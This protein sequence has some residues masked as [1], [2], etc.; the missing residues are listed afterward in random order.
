M[1]STSVQSGGAD[2]PEEIPDS[3]SDNGIDKISLSKDG[4]K[5]GRVIG[6]FGFSSIECDTESLEVTLEC[7]LGLINRC[8]LTPRT[9]HAHDCTLW[10]SSCPAPATTCSPPGRILPRVHTPH[11]LDLHL[12]FFV[13]WECPIFSIRSTMYSLVF[14]CSCWLTCLLLLA[15]ILRSNTP[16]RPLYYTCSDICIFKA[17]KRRPCQCYCSQPH[18]P[19]IDPSF[20]PLDMRLRVDMADCGQCAV[21]YPQRSTD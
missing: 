17:R 2:V 15:C 6:R 9:P 19:R 1:A 7:D 14:V 18:A 12:R 5:Y 3:D 10:H 16:A 4:V 13:L 20:V 8:V 21:N 11:A